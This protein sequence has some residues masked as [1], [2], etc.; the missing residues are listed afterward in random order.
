[1]RSEF[2]IAAALLLLAIAVNPV[3]GNEAHFGV[4][5]WTA[6]DIAKHLQQDLKIDVPTT[7]ITALGLQGSTL[8]AVPDIDLSGLGL[9][10]AELAAVRRSL[11]Q[12]LHRVNS[13][14]A[15]FWEWRAANRRLFDSWIGPLSLSPRALLFWMRFYDSNEAIGEHDLPCPH[16]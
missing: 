7:A 5:D 2:A 11:S 13:K 12:L 8:F 16:S 9:K 1:M 6:D 4:D 15:D 14:P 10:P 3:H